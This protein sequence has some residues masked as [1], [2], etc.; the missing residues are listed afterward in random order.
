MRCL[1]KS[2]CIPKGYTVT[3]TPNINDKFKI[4]ADGNRIFAGNLTEIK[5]TYMW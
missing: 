2:V 4:V 1:P 3:L 5:V